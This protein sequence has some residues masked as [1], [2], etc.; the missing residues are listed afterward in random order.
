MTYWFNYLYNESPNPN[1]SASFLFGSVIASEQEHLL[2]QT[3]QQEQREHKQAFFSM[4]SKSSHTFTF[5]LEE[6]STKGFFSSN[7]TFNPALF[8]KMY[9]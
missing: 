6:Y 2:E 9:F 7:R 1:S 4:Q 8:D 5:V 3:E